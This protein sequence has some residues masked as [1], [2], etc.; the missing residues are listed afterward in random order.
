[1]LQYE[2]PR[3]PELLC[4]RSWRA[5]RA[6][7]NLGLLLARVQMGDSVGR[8]DHTDCIPYGSTRSKGIAVR[9]TEMFYSVAKNAEFTKPRIH[10]FMQQMSFARRAGDLAHGSLV[11]S[12]G[13][14]GDKLPPITLVKAY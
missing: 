8:A 4:G 3:I 13:S 7:P 2:R 9:V 1:M 10:R 14:W 6:A 12:K 11:T 5:R